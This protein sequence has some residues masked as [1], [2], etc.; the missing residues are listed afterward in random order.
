MPSPRKTDSSTR[1]WSRCPATTATRRWTEFDP[2]STDAPTTGRDA[3]GRDA[4]ALTPVDRPARASGRGVVDA[5]AGR[6]KG[7]P[8]WGPRRGGSRGC[9]LGGRRRLRCGSRRARRRGLGS[10]RGRLGRPRQACASPRRAWSLPRWAWSLPAWSPPAW[11]SPAGWSP[12]RRACPSP[13]AGLATAGLAVAGLAAVAA[14]EPEAGVRAVLFPAVDGFGVVRGFAV[15]GFVGGFA[16]VVG[17]A[18]AAA[19]GAAIAGVAPA[20]AAADLGVAVR[21]RGV[22][23]A[24][25]RADFGAVAAV[26]EAVVDVAAVF[27]VRTGVTAWAAWAAAD[28]TPRAASPTVV[29]AEPAAEPTPRAASPTVLAAE[30]AAEPASPAIFA[31]SLATSASAATACLRR[32]AIS[33]RPFEARAAASCLSRFDSVFR[34]DVSRFSSRRS[35]L[36]ALLE[37]GVTA[38]LASTTTSDTASIAVPARL[39]PDA[40]ASSR[41]AIVRPP[42][43]AR[44]ARP[45]TAAWVGRS[46]R[47]VAR[48]QVCHVRQGSRGS[49]RHAGHR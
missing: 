43:S 24:A 18:L 23:A 3:T 1:I 42:F 25:F 31:A 28:P 34:A 40:D 13:R 35:S 39:L 29:A 46:R 12:P 14:L 20:L 5:V 37:S 27:G 30:P 32:F 22:A 49:S 16:L 48:W 11:S 7:P 19:E 15:V 44:R 6:L 33:L 8:G 26:L 45:R 17:F 2:R 9:G 4:T 36:A 21:R 38:P 47:T 41:L 10:R